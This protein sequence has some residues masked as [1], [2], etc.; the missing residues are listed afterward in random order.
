LFESPSLRVSHLGNPKSVKAFWAKEVWHGL[1]MFGT[2]SLREIDKPTV[3]MFL[4]LGLLVCGIILLGW[5]AISQEWKALVAGVLVAFVV[6]ALAVVYRASR[7]QRR[8]PFVTGIFLYQ[9]YFL[10]R[11]RALLQIVL[12]RLGSRAGS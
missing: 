1:G 4:H 5:A 7:L 2:F 9:L 6:P 8:I 10:A 12:L 11:L 3:M